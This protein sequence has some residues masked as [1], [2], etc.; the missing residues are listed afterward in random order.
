MKLFLG[1]IIVGLLIFASYT[2]LFGEQIPVTKASG[3]TTTF[4]VSHPAWQ[5]VCHSDV[6]KIAS[7]VATADQVVALDTHSAQQCVL[8]K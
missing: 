5:L 3:T 7:V 8:Y 6:Y 1:T 2:S 4:T